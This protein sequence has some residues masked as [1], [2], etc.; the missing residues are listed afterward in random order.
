MILAPI[1][2]HGLP[3]PPGIPVPGYL[4]AWAAAIVLVASF[5]A[6]GALWREP[7]LEDDETQ[8]LLRLAVW[9]QPA[10][11]LLGVATF[12]LLVYAGLE[13]TPVPGRNLAPT[14]V[15]VVFWVGLVP[16]TVL[17]GDVFSLFNPWRAVGRAVGWLT[18]RV[19]DEWIAPPLAYPARLGYWPAVA[20]LAAFAWLE[21]V[22]PGRSA[23]D[24][25][26]AAAW[27]YAAAQLVG[28]AL[29]GVDAWTRRGDA[30]SV[31]FGLFSRLSL[32]RLRGRD[33]FVGRP[34]SAA[35]ELPIGAGIVAV[36]CVM[37]GTTSFDGLSST[38]Q[39]SELAPDLQRAFTSL[40]VSAHGATELAGTAGLA[41]MI[42]L[43]A[44]IYRMGVSGMRS[45]DRGFRRDELA[46]R[47]IHTL[48]PI[49]AAYVM[50]H[51]FT[52]LVFQGQA[53]DALVSDPL[54]HG[55][56]LFGTAHAAIDYSLFSKAAVWY[57]QV[58]ALVCGHVGGL[59]LAHDRALAVYQAGR[60][61]TRSQYWML[62]VMVGFTSLGLFLLASIKR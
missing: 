31:Y 58:G 22:Y 62:T 36:L 47:F 26:A 4:F 17:L 48:I 43:V 53:M 24:T 51:Y 60:R 44:G 10:C 40:G 54:G 2:A 56:D 61:A 27:V 57:V 49:A 25:V 5:S 39:W 18:R 35:T 42:L 8:R 37:I 12:A 30:F 19:S 59:V 11:G 45:V 21:L 52:F 23:P 1:L 13:G 33:V 6:L 28:M 7:R 3:S 34:L 29:F 9:V 55:S 20:G 14:F 16:V 50:A 32:V 41:A 38:V 15:Y 46:R